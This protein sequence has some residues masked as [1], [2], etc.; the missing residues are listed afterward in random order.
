MAGNPRIDEL[1]KKLD[2]EPG[3]RLFAQLAEELRKD[4]DLE[5]AIRVAREGLQKHSNYPSA[6]MTLGRALFDTG[7]WSAARAEFEL[8][9]KGAPDNILASR[10]LAESLESLGDVPAAIARYKKTLALAPG[11]KQVLARLDALE[12]PGAPLG[13]ASAGAAAPAAAAPPPAAPRAPIPIVAV[14]TPMELEQAHERATAFAPGPAAPS[15]PAAPRPPSSESV[16]VAPPPA[17]SEPAPI[18]LVAADEEFELERPYEPPQPSVAAAPRPP[19]AAQAGGPSATPPAPHPPAESS[20]EFEFD[21]GPSGPTIPFAPAPAP[22]PAESA[23]PTPAPPP[24]PS[25]PASVAAPPLEAPPPPAVAA[26]EERAAFE[27]RPHS[28]APP[29]AANTVE[30]PWAAPVRRPSAAAPAPAFAPE[31]EPQPAPAPPT[32]PAPAP[33]PPPP[34]PAPAAPSPAPEAASGELMSATLAE[35]YFKQGFAEKAVEVYRQLIEREPENDRLRRRLAELQD[36]RPAPA[37]ASDTGTDQP[38]RRVALQR[39]IAKLEGML[40]AIRKG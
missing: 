14:D 29:A 33:A 3:S 10:L 16:S 38:S 32:A 24:P 30:V 31:P 12:K 4:G 28:P 37:P 13:A 15:P 21:A 1:R 36:T 7:D 18:P 2:K 20:M 40:A 17:A 8:V 9:L 27:S 26:P 39:T 11:D 34:P 35:L 22:A 23:P 5:D 25:V 19:A 6:R